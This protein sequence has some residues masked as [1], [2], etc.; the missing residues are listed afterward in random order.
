MILFCPRRPVRSNRVGLSRAGSSPL[1]WLRCAGSVGLVAVMVLKGP[2]AAAQ[3][4]DGG[5]QDFSLSGMSDTQNT[6]GPVKPTHGGRQTRPSAKIPDSGSSTCVQVQVSGEKPD[7]YACINQKMQHTAQQEAALPDTPINPA[8]PQNRTGAVN[9]FG[10]SEQYGG[11][12]GKSVT[13]YRP[14]M[15]VFQGLPPH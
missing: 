4:K 2:Y 14:A 6:P 10:V 9:G 3:G 7:P 13:P 15:P 5:Q 1:A 12:L 8:G 11:N